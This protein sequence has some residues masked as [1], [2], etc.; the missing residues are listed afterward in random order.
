MDNLRTKSEIIKEITKKAQRAKPMVRNVFL[1]G[2]K[3]RTK[4]E[5]SSID[6]S[7]KISRSGWD[8]STT[9]KG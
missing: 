4:R 5:L 2:L 3:W 9:R 8:I 1:R 7:M 6:R